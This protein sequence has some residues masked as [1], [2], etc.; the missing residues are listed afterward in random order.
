MNKFRRKTL[1]VI[2]DRL[3]DIRDNLDE[4]TGEE[5]E[6]RDG[7]PENLQTSERHEKAD[8]ACDNLCEAISD[9]E[10]AME[11]IEASIEQQ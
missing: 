6:Y 10:A 11:C 8:E 4:I 7:M 2:L 9:L 5:E 3:A 1:R